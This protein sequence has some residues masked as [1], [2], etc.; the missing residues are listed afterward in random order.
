M[1]QISPTLSTHPFANIIFLSKFDFYN[2]KYFR[3]DSRIFKPNSD[4]TK[5][6]HETRIT[7]KIV[8]IG[9]CVLNRTFLALIPLQTWFLFPKISSID[10]MTTYASHVF[11]Y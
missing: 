5:K 9:Y 3:F 1:Y 10:K 4:N 7:Q 6:K 8:W 11:S 2:W